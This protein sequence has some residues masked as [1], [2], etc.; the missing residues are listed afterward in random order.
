[1][2]SVECWVLSGECCLLLD[3]AEE[4]E[5]VWVAQLHQPLHLPH[6][7]SDHLGP[8]PRRLR[9]FHLRSNPSFQERLVIFRIHSIIVMIRWTGLAPWELEWGENEKRE[10]VEFEST[11]K[12]LM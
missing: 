11:R 12:M 3:G 10:E 6:R 4:C 5:D 1:M 7:V 9:A 2:L 8:L